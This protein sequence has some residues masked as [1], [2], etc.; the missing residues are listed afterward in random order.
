MCPSELKLLP[1]S[2]VSHF[3][4]PGQTSGSWIWPDTA[5]AI[6]VVCRVN[7]KMKISLSLPLFLSL[8]LFHCCS[9]FEVNN[10]YL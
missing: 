7:L 1:A 10:M 9:D 5:L 2:L 3:G 8:C 4:V 6:A